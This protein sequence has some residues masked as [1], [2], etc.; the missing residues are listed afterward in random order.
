MFRK[1]IDYI[2]YLINNSTK[3]EIISNI[4]TIVLLIL[5][6]IFIFVDFEKINIFKNDET[7]T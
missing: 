4:L 7:Q 5:L 6:M 1:L 3:K 2:E